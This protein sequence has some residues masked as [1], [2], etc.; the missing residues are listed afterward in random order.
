MCLALNM[1]RHY[2]NLDYNLTMAKH[3]KNKAK[4]PS[5]Y[6][7]AQLRHVR[8]MR[9]LFE[10]HA[11][12]GIALLTPFTLIVVISLLYRLTLPESDSLAAYY[13]SWVFNSTVVVLWAIVFPAAALIINLGSLKIIVG[14]H[15]FNGKIRPK[16]LLRDTWQSLTIVF[17]VLTLFTLVFGAGVDGLRAFLQGI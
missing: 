5:R 16:A 17:I 6:H 9:S 2:A 11:A 1:A 10:H 13:G 12:T 7:L 15:R 4:K 14:D 3:K 8:R